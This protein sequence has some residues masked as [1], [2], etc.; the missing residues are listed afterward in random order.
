MYTNSN[1]K[2]KEEK[3]EII[4]ALVHS[5]TRLDLVGFK[6]SEEKYDR[7]AVILFTKLSEKWDVDSWS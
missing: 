4:R 2:I 6:F 1:H 7:S 3:R 5:F